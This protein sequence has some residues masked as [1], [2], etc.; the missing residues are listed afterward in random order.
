[1]DS[2]DKAPLHIHK[3]KTTGKTALLT[4]VALCVLSTSWLQRI[5]LGPIEQYGEVISGA[6]SALAGVVFWVG[7]VISDGI[8]LDQLRGLVPTLPLR[9]VVK[10]QQFKPS[11]TVAIRLVC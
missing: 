1:L 7:P 5:R 8:R 3:H 6:F 2:E 9:P 10:W 4:Y 11:E